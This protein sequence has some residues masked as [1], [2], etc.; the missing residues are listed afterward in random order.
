MEKK[1]CGP[2]AAKNCSS[3]EW[4]APY[5]KISKG[6]IPPFVLVAGDPARIA[7]IAALCETAEEIAYNREYQTFVGTFQCTRLAMTS[8]GIGAAGAAICSRS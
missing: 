6:S 8:H 3:D 2:Q 7:K 5:L 1:D 4:L